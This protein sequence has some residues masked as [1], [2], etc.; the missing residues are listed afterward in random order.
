MLSFVVIEHAQ[1]DCYIA[2]K[3]ILR[4]YPASQIR[5]FG[6]IAS[7]VRSLDEANGSAGNTPDIVLLDLM[8]PD[9]SGFHFLEIFEKLETK[10]R[11]LYFIVVLTSSL[12]K[13][14]LSRLRGNPLVRIV[15]DKP[16]TVKKIQTIIEA[17]HQSQESNF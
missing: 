15:L 17:L 1:L 14:E 8:M 6:T 11:G 5:F 16:M 3:V 12:N 13:S 9:G 4:E 10:K 2:K 7:A